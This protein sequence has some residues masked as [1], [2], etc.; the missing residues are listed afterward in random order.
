MRASARVR[1]NLYIHMRVNLHVGSCMQCSKM[2][3][4]RPWFIARAR[5]SARSHPYLKTIPCIRLYQ[6]A[7]V[8]T[9]ALVFGALQRAVLQNYERAR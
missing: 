5:Q 8:C 2:A 6:F 4:M 9:R 1:V 7:G 3:I